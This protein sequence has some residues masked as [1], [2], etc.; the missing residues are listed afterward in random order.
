MARYVVIGPSVSPFVRKVRVI[1]ALKGQDYAHEAIDLSAPP[2]DF[3]E[4]SPLRRVPVLRDR[5]RAGATLADSS[6][7]ALYLDRAHPEPRLI[8]D[9]PWQ[10]GQVAFLEEYADTDFAYRLGMGV[11]RAR[12]MNPRLGKPLDEALAQR[13]MAEVAP[14]FFEFFERTL[15]GRRFLVGEGLTLAD[16]AVATHFVNFGYGGETVDA[17]RWPALAAFAQH[18]LALPA[19]AELIAAEAR[20]LGLPAPG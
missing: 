15:D 7:I 11:F 2:A 17:A 19:F 20:E 10:A 16:I 1:L 18:M 6:A 3:L 13:A 5:A 14:R 9:D 4:I 12:F 8:P